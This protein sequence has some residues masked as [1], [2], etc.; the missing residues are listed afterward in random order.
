MDCACCA[1][2]GHCW[3]F[4]FSLKSFAFAGFDDDIEADGENNIVVFIKPG[5]TEYWAMVAAKKFPL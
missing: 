5:G 2:C 1:R 4:F 3:A